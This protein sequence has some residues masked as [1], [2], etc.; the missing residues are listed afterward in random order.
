[1]SQWQVMIDER[2]KRRK[3]AGTAIGILG[4]G[5]NRLVTVI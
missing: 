4:Y 3:K 5:S 1:M 2:S